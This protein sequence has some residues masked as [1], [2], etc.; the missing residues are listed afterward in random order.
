MRSC[1]CTP[2]PDDDDEPLGWRTDLNVSC[3]MKRTGCSD[4]LGFGLGR[5]EGNPQTPQPG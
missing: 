4:G 3:R 1:F 2:P 5:R